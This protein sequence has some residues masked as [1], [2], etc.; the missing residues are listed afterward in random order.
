MT[1]QSKQDGLFSGHRFTPDYMPVVGPFISEKIHNTLEEAYNDDTL[2]ND[3]SAY[4]RFRGSRIKDM[5]LLRDM[6]DLALDAYLYD[7]NFK[8]EPHYSELTNFL[9]RHEPEPLIILNN[10][11]KWIAVEAPD[12]FN[13]DAKRQAKD[14]LVEH[15]QLLAARKPYSEM[16]HQFVAY[17]DLLMACLVTAEAKMQN[18]PP[19]NIRPLFGVNMWD[20]LNNY[21]NGAILEGFRVTPLGKKADAEKIVYKAYNI[22]SDIAKGKEDGFLDSP[23][24]YYVLYS[25]GALTGIFYES[26]VTVFVHHMIQLVVD[27]LLFDSIYE[28]EPHWLS[29]LEAVTG[30]YENGALSLKLYKESLLNPYAKYSREVWDSVERH[31]LALETPDDKEVEPFTEINHL[32][33]NN[34]YYNTALLMYA[35]KYGV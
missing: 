18:L 14:E 4:A 12:M 2:N 35:E 25:M 7:E 9:K 23:Y 3:I 21:E 32:L 17:V 34:V 16:G 10:Y 31:F 28:I 30:R 11:F 13:T 22:T 33:I 20:L 24:V 8:R 5:Q 15:F 29:I 27:I 6:Y 26:E 19:K 1:K